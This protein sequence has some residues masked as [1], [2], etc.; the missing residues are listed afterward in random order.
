[1]GKFSSDFCDLE[2]ALLHG[3]AEVA[4]PLLEKY[5][6]LRLGGDRSIHDEPLWKLVLSSKPSPPE[7]EG[8]VRCLNALLDSGLR[9]TQRTQ[10]GLSLLD[11][12]PFVDEAFSQALLARPKGVMRVQ[13]QWGTLNGRAQAWW[14]QQIARHRQELLGK[15]LPDATQEPSASPRI[16]L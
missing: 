2:L 6:G 4:C 13:A 11:E 16:R 15:N 5:K 10:K 7:L 14:G 9:V 1:M 3:D 8:R 12:L